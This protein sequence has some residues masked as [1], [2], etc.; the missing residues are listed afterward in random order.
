[1]KS[2]YSL[3]VAASIALADPITVPGSGVAGKCSSTPIT[4]A[5]FN[6]TIPSPGITGVYLLPKAEYD[7]LTSASQAPSQTP[8]QFNYYIDY[9]CTGGA[10]TTCSKSTG[11]SKLNSDIICVALVNAG[12]NST[13][14]GDLTVSFDG[15][16]ANG[17]TRAGVALTMVAAASWLLL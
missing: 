5:S 12:T 7:K 3:L 15:G 8:V 2:L 10:V 11:S 1:M 14:N 9:S 13:A 16:S 17:A 4:T 6:A